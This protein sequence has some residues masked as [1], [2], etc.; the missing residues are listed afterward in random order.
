MLEF[1][2]QAPQ[3]L[4]RFRSSPAGPYVDGFAAALNTAGYARLSGGSLLRYAVHLGLWADRHGVMTQEI[5]E[6]VVDG[7]GE[8]LP[9][10]DCPGQRA[11]SHERGA[12]K[13]SVFLRY[14]RETGVV[15]APVVTADVA[16]DQCTVLRDFCLWLKCHRAI[17][18]S[19]IRAYGRFVS[20]F[21]DRLGEDPSAYTA[22]DVRRAVQDQA[23]QYGFAEAKRVATALR[24]FL[25]YLAGIGECGPYLVDAVP[26]VAGWRL[27]TLPRHLPP[28][29]VERL[30]A[31]CRRDTASGLRDHAIL[32]LLSRLGLRAGDVVQLALGDIDWSAARI[33]VSGKSR[34]AVRLPL[35][36]AVGDAILAYLDR[37]R[38]Q[39]DTK[40]VFLT[41]RPPFRALAGSSTVSVIVKRAIRRAAVCA[42]THGAH[43]LRH[44]AATAMLRQGASL[45]GIG[46][47]LRHRSVETTAHY[48]RVDARL[49]RQVAQ[50][51]REAQPC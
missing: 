44:S 49:L 24:M 38:P 51:W 25:R 37:G 12:A 32:L 46:A 23:A 29:D 21:L 15:C 18:E 20:V 34:C 13:A 5:D 3:T 31:S 9:R 17:T 42:P 4:R 27:T 48:A 19:T 30:L 33:V 8:H 22:Q 39:V 16:S 47:V 35:P 14:L 43:L 2:L 1:Y 40:R 41:V 10:C 36:Q 28:E 26:T 50:P 6:P 45:P 7:F 11:G